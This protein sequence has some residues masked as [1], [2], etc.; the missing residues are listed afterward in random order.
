MVIPR[1]NDAYHVDK[2]VSRGV[3]EHLVGTVRDTGYEIFCEE[4]FVLLVDF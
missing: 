2:K 3:I 1:S 4:M